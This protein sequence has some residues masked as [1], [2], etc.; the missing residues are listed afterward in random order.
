MEPAATAR[1]SGSSPR[2]VLVQTLRVPPPPDG[3][4]RGLT[5]DDRGHLHTF[6]GTF[7]PHLSTYDPGTGG[8]T[9]RTHSG[10][11]TIG[12]TT[13][14]TPSPTAAASPMAS[15]GSSATAR[16]HGAS[17]SGRTS[18]MSPCCLSQ[19]AGALFIRPRHAR[20]PPPALD[21]SQRHPPPVVGA[22]RLVTDRASHHLL[23]QQSDPPLARPVLP[24]N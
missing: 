24:L 21:D 3:A 20:R 2:G 6:N 18:S 1:T 10:W 7:Q 15:S 17:P 4:V 22:R 11:N 8:W 9:H 14:P 23:Y 5:L 13:R 19:P 16:G 12:N